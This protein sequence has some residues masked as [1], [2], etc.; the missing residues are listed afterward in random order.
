MPS[1]I[2]SIP[3]TAS[4]LHH[5]SLYRII[6]KFSSSSLAS[7][8]SSIWRFN[9]K[10]FKEISYLELP[11]QQTVVDFDW[12]SVQ[13]LCDESRSQ[14]HDIQLKTF[15][16]VLSTLP[17]VEKMHPM[18]GNIA[19][20]ARE[21][22]INSEFLKVYALDYSC[23]LR[24]YLKISDQE[25]D[26]YQQEFLDSGCESID[27][28]LNEYIVGDNGEEDS[29]NAKQFRETLKLSLLAR[30]KLWKNVIL[31]PRDDLPQYTKKHYVQ[32]LEKPQTS[33]GSGACLVRTQG[34]FMPWLNINDF[35]SKSKKSIPPYG[36]L[37]N[38]DQF[39]VRGWCNERWCSCA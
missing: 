17:V 38:G 2:L 1:A 9:E 29:L 33:A 4:V 36:R 20:K 30:D 5:E 22:R 28:F 27:K 23:R 32:Q 12:R 8:A 18:S 3:T 14:F 19:T 35:D 7:V 31:P 13:E 16:T 26:L 37:A 21:P 24:N 34:K 15:K 11:Q 6:H 39:T 10:V 25:L